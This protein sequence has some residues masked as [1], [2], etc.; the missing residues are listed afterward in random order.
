M[1]HNIDDLSLAQLDRKRS[2]SK[3]LCRSCGIELAFVHTTL[4]YKDQA[5]TVRVLYL[6]LS[7]K[8]DKDGIYKLP[9]RVAEEAKRKGLARGAAP[10]HASQLAKR[11]VNDPTIPQVS[12]R[13]YH[14]HV[15]DPFSPN[16]T[17]SYRLL[18]AAPQLPI[19]MQCYKC[20][21]VQ[22]LDAEVLGI[23]E[24][25]DGASPYSGHDGRRLL[26]VE[27]S[28]NGFDKR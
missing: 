18:Q 4:S 21:S 2:K 16:E 17:F 23:E 11:W 22:R 12:D 26:F 1:I 8:L 28:L 9:P 3:V 24:T 13:V 15:S 7:W 27:Y 19:K 5:T 20:G 25:L 6:D 14:H 10:R